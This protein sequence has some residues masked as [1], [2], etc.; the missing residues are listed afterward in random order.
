MGCLRGHAIA[1]EIARHAG[2]AEL[3][4][5]ALGGL[6]DAEYV[7]GRMIS[8]YDRFRE[9]VDLSGLLRNLGS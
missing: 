6:G 1:L 5:M 8:A 9:C 2:A 7:R 3:E 4:A